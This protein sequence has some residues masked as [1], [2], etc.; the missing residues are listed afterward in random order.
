MDEKQTFFVSFGKNTDGSLYHHGT[1]EN[2]DIVNSW[3]KDPL[4]YYIK[5]LE[6]SADG[7]DD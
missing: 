7:N 5:V 4:V 1:T 6:V 2:E 3:Y